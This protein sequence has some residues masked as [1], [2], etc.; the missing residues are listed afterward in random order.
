MNI[1]I[2]QVKAKTVRLNCRHKNNLYVV[3]I[4]KFKISITVIN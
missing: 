4:S 1:R 2:V 3:W